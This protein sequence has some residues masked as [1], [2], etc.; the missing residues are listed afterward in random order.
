MKDIF[1][2]AFEGKVEYTEGK[3]GNTRL[4][5]AGERCIVGLF[6]L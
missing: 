1:G 6:N 4:E 3:Y 2:I 5:L